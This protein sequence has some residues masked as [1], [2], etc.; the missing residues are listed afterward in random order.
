V[1]IARVIAQ[2]SQPGRRSRRH[3]HRR[4]W[5]FR[6]IAKVAGAPGEFGQHVPEVTRTS[7]LCPRRAAP[8][9]SAS[10]DD[11]R[12]CARAAAGTIQADAPDFL[13][14]SWVTEGG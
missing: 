6:K 10:R 7:L 9:E 3:V 1:I 12:D 11:E 2:V 14:D 4:L 8:G 13:G 5:L